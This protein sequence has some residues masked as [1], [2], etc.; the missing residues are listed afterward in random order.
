VKNQ[1]TNEIKVGVTVLAGILIF[2]FGITQFSDWSIKSSYDMLSFRFPTSGGLQVGDPVFMNGV[3]IGKAESVALEGNKVVVRCSILKDMRLTSDAVATIQVL[4]LMGGKKI[5]IKQGVNPTPMDYSKTIEGTVDPDFG[6]M[7]AF[8]GSV[9]GNI[10]DLGV[11]ANKLVNNANAIIGDESMIN[12]LK[13]SAA[14][15]QAIS[16]DVRVLLKDNRDD[17]QITAQTLSRLS[18]KADT[19]VTLL[20]P[21]LTEGLDQTNRTLSKVDTLVG[22]VHGM[23]REFRD[24]RGLVNK[25][26]NDTTMNGRIDA[27]LVKLDSLTN[28]IINGQMRIKIRL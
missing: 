22:D 23:V 17:I 6:S 16:Q 11:N 28:I 19:L 15:L 12:S 21:K 25:L 3:R 5:E 14:N 8:V 4:E 24:S 18:R 9:Q 1:R 27:M 10:T 7:L 20:Q 13:S 26:L 2:I